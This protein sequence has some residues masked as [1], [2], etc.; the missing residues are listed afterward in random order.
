MT[1]TVSR[2]RVGLV[3]SG[4]GVAGLAVLG[5][6]SLAQAQGGASGP[7][8]PS[9]AEKQQALQAVNRDANLSEAARNEKYQAG[10]SE[11]ARRRAD[12]IRAFQASGRSAVDL[13]RVELMQSEVS[14]PPTLRAAV[15]HARRVVSGR[16]VSHRYTPDGTVSTLQVEDSIKGGPIQ[17]LTFTQRGGPEP[18]PGYG[19][20][21]VVGYSIADPVLLGQQSVLLF[22]AE[23]PGDQT[24]TLRPESFVGQ[25]VVEGDRVQPLPGNPFRSQFAGKSLGEVKQAV[26]AEMQKS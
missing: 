7:G 21:A 22:L 2:F 12:W 23:E 26:R 16:V 1:R 4:L 3:A 17:T 9:A 14:P 10:L 6:V 11:S 20:D 15:G 19:D 24:Q 18:L 5:S 8:G 13:P 25:Y